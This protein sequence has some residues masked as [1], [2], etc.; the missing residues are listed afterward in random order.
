MKTWGQGPGGATALYRDP[1]ERIRRLSQW[2]A[3]RTHSF[4]DELAEFLQ[5]Q[6]DVPAEDVY[7]LCD[8]SILVLVLR[9]VV[10]HIVTNIIRPQ[11]LD[12]VKSATEALPRARRSGGGEERSGPLADLAEQR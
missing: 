8:N 5:R 7:R 3:L 1:T 12:K 2:E 11:V 6:P 10:D 4:P 9:D